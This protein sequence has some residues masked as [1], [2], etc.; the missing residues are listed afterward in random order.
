MIKVIRLTALMRL[1]KDLWLRCDVEEKRALIL[2][3]ERQ[4]CQ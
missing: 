3:K 2:V 4:S 1:R